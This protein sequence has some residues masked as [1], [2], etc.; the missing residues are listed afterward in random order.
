MARGGAQDKTEAPTPRRLQEARRRGQVAKSRDFSAAVILMA[1]VLLCYMLQV[2]ATVQWEQELS[3]YFSHCFSFDLPPQNL[4]WVLYDVGMHVMRMFAPFFVVLV[5]AALAVNIWQT[6]FIFSTESLKFSPDRLNPVNGLQRLFSLRSLVELAKS[7]LKVL[8]VGAVSFL[9]VKSRLPALLMIFTRPAEA[10]FGTVSGTLL[11]VAAAA[12]GTFLGLAVLD[13]YFQR[14]SFTRDMR[15]SKQ[16]VKDELKQTEGDP[17]VK[18]W[19]RRRMR[20]ILLN[21]IRQEVPRATV[22]ITNPTHVAVALRYAE[23]EMAAPQVVAKGAGDLARRIR[24]I[25]A[26]NNVPVMPKP[27]L[28]RALYQQVEIGAEIPVELYQAVAQI[29]AL[30][31]RLKKRRPPA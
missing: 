25:A 27:E 12:G 15:M 26:E 1:A 14:W 19:Q 30:V 29:L 13:M 21:R 28:A 10:A 20:Q 17:V 4:P 7:V 23:D 16:E 3:W 6:G 31:Y 22:V 8:V 18:G 24:E 11:A 2:R 9:T 5:G